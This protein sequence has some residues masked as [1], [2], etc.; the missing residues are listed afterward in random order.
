MMSP[1][2]IQDTM[3]EGGA[4]MISVKS[5]GTF[6][7]IRVEAE[8]ARLESLLVDLRRLRAG[9]HPSR[10][11]LAAAPSID[12][13]TMERR[14]VPCLVGLIQGHPGLPAMSFSATSDVWILDDQRGYARTLSRIYALG[15]RRGERTGSVQ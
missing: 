6:D 4:S 9:G 8:I 2:G 1:A 14:A 3:N 7:R 11:E 5:D 12:Q 15:L 13:W 10:A